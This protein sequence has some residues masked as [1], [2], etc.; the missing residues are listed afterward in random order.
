MGELNAYA[1]PTQTDASPR[2]WRCSK[3]L[4]EQVTRPW[5]IVC[6]RCKGRNGDNGKKL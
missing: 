6:P 5:S 4:A 3:L 2:C 1:K